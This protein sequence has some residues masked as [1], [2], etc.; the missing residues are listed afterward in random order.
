M[1][2]TSRGENASPSCGAEHNGR[3]SGSAHSKASS[4]LIPF[5]IDAILNSPHPRKTTRPRI[6]RTQI[7]TASQVTGC[8][9]SSLEKFTSV[10]LKDKGET[11]SKE[12]GRFT[13]AVAEFRIVFRCKPVNF[14][15]RKLRLLP[16][17]NELST[18]IC[19]DL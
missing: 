15:C 19:T 18:R 14:G 1:A 9:L 2:S 13:H 16:L 10:S 4:K 11:E 6:R 3:I 12:D 7:V 17:G 5:S 8:A